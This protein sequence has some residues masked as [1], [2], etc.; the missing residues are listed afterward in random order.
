MQN[1]TVN[2]NKIEN[3]IF[4][5][6]TCTG[7]SACANICQVNAIRLEENEIGYYQLIIDEE[8]C[9]HCGKCE[10]V[11]PEINPI[12]GNTTKP[13]VYACQANDDI[14]Y[15]SSS[16]GVFTL[17]A[18]EILAKGGYVAGVG[19]DENWKV[20]HMII[21]SIEKLDKLRRSKYVQSYIR[22]DFYKEIEKLL[23]NDNYVLF[24]GCPCQAAGLRSYLGKNYDKLYIVDL[25]CAHSASPKAYRKFLADNYPGEE[26]KNINFRSKLLGWDSNTVVTTNKHINEEITPNF[27][28]AFVPHLMMN[29]CCKNCKY[30][31]TSR[32]GDITIGD[33]WG[34]GKR[35]PHLDDRKG[36]SCVL[37]NSEKG[38]QIF[39]KIKSKFKLIEK[40]TLK[41]AIKSNCVLKIPFKPHPNIDIFNKN[42]D[43]KNFN[44]NTIDCLSNKYTVGVVD[45]WYAPNRGAILTNYAL[46]EAINELGYK[47]KTIN[48]IPDNLLQKYKGSI[49]ESFATKYLSLTREIRNPN[50]LTKL[51]KD[52][53]TFI[54]G[55]DQIW[56]YLFRKEPFG[57]MFLNFVNKNNKMISYSTSFGTEKYDGPESARTYMRHYLSKFDAIS[58]REDQAV[59]ILKEDFNIEGTQVIDPVFLI[60]K[61]KYD[62]LIE[63]ST[64]TDKKYIAYYILFNNKDK[65]N[66][67]KITAKNL[68]LKVIN[69]AGNNNVEDWLYYIKNCEILITDSFHGTCFATIFNK[70][71]IAVNPVKEK[72]TRFE[73][74]LKIT[75]MMDRFLYTPAEIENK[76]YL[77]EDIDWTEAN[78]NLEKEIIRGKNWL[79]E[80][81]NKPRKELTEE[82]RFADY[83]LNKDQI[84]QNNINSRIKIINNKHKIYFKYYF[85]RIF[86]NITFG[87]VK[88][89]LQNQKNRYKPMIRKLR[90]L[91]GNI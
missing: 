4:R 66:L 40:R 49:A 27:M 12:K 22:E 39:N 11:C 48:Y 28:R 13:E 79:R 68:K 83:L 77:F 42:I 19:F 33:Y 88:K 70:K 84:I 72:P 74:I 69:I 62:N 45:F 1:M 80:A 54:C 75:N 15:V 55:S 36:T 63:N 2:K 38:K 43:T 76:E 24:S 9:V 78:K 64:K 8:K 52:I 6:T 35:A 25:L 73:T 16:G 23:K 21:N 57:H 56:R 10:K 81:L 65:E 20:H 31:T 46:N 61:E 3:G 50:E 85:A 67:I 26:I 87:S 41:D 86:Y 44:E 89:N 60:S 14:R 34:I 37:I 53:G 5:V 29:E 58:V 82:Q 71:F 18:E 30:T 90:E 7:C 59:K 91:K 47:C 51:N 17:L 32:Q